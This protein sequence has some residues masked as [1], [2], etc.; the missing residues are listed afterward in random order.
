[1]SWRRFQLSGLPQ[2]NN[3][4]LSLLDLCDDIYFMFT[5][6]FVK[7]KTNTFYFFVMLT[8]EVIMRKFT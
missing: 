2:H 5:V 1:M 6:H 4:K 8:D 3:I 7:L